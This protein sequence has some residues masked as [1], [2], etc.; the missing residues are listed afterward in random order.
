M[1][2][3]ELLFRVQNTDDFDRLALHPI[4][5]DVVFVQDQFADFGHWPRP[6]K[7]REGFELAKLLRPIG[8][9]FSGGFYVLARDVIEYRFEISS[10]PLRPPKRHILRRRRLLP[11]GLR[12]PRDQ[13]RRVL[14]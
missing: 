7:K 1:S 6:A 4:V 8:G 3:R 10:G 13:L 12:T 2:R 14:L 11:L 5:R 9:Q